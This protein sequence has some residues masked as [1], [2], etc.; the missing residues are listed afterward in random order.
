MC[1]VPRYQYQY[2]HKTNPIPI[3]MPIPISPQYRGLGSPHPGI[4]ADFRSFR[5][6]TS[7]QSS[8]KLVFGF[9]KS[10]GLA[11][12]LVPDGFGCRGIINENIIFEKFLHTYFCDNCNFYAVFFMI[13][14]ICITFPSNLMARPIP[15]HPS[16]PNSTPP[17]LSP[18]REGPAL[19][20]LGLARPDTVKSK[21][22][23]KT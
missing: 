12:W 6:V 10:W 4:I 23:W 22:K 1:W 2:Q 8:C 13:C 11:I 15:P 9:T 20:A 3:P 7:W 21:S 16:H 5:K 18:C 14:G 19:A 17:I